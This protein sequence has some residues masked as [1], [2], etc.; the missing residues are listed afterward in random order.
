MIGSFKTGGAERMSINTGQELSRRGYDVFYLIQKPIFEIPNSIP[1]DRIV[2][3]RSEKENGLLQKV[4]SLFV[5]VYFEVRKIKPDVIIAFS[6][7]SSFLACFSL[8]RRIIGRFDMNPFT[9]SRKQRIWANVVI[10]SPFVRKIVVPSTGMFRALTEARPGKTEKFIV[11]ANSID[12]DLVKVKARD[13]FPGFDFPFICAMGRLAHQKNFSLLIRAFG[14]SNL[15]AVAKLVIIGDG[16]LRGQI[17]AEIKGLDLTDNVIITG[18]LK[19]PFP[20]LK[21]ALFL[22]NT[23]DRESF[24][25]VILEGLTLSLPVVAT[26]CDYGPEDMVQNG[27]NGFLTKTGDESDLITALN[28]L[29]ENKELLEQLRKNAESSVEKFQISKVVDSWERLINEVTQK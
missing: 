19:N 2:V 24:C 23:S 27:V 22:V 5:G 18:Q 14:K 11:V 9:L 10:S 16:V 25:N 13:E 17:E 20:L 1:R 26:N 29:T 4:Y 12:K 3:L 8:H 7:F 6:R 21:K 28:K 15:R